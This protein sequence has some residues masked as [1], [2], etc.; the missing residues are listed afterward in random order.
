MITLGTGV[1]GGL[2]LNG[3]L[4]RGA[5]GAAP[6]IGHTIVG[7]DLRTGAPP[8]GERFPQAG[9]FERLAAGTELDR[10]ALAAATAA[11]ESALGRELAEQGRVTGHDVVEA[12]QAGDARAID[13]LRVLGER[14]GIGIANAINTFDPLEVVIGGGVSRAGELLLGP[15]RE[16]ASRYVL[17]GVGTA[18]TIRLAGKGVEAGVL[19]AALLAKIEHQHEGV[20]AGL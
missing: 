15:A 5:T 11:P 18:C 9:S 8:P 13:V 1:G 14:L 12:A 16:T 19:G 17:P 7:M 10:L 2:V 6:E 3:R 4:Y 20:V